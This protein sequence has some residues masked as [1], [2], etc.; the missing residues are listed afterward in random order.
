MFRSALCAAVFVGLAGLDV[1]AFRI[2]T[3]AS[4]L[5]DRDVELEAREG[6]ARAVSEGGAR[7]VKAAWWLDRL[8]ESL[9]HANT[10]DLE[11]L[12]M[13]AQRTADLDVDLYGDTSAEAARSLARLG[14]VLNDCGAAADAESVLRRALASY[15]ALGGSPDPDHAAAHYSLGIVLKSRERWVAAREH[16]QASL[17]MLEALGLGDA[18]ETVDIVGSLAV[19][20]RETGQLGD[21]RA[22]FERQLAIRRRILGEQHGL[23]ADAWN[24][25]GT[26]LVDLGLSADAKS[27]YQRAIAIYELNGGPPNSGQANALFNY[28]I[29]LSADLANARAVEFVEKGTELHKVISG[30]ESAD[31]AGCLTVLG[32]VYAERGRPEAA[33]TIFGQAATLWE[34]LRGPEHSEVAIALGNRA[35][36]L[37]Q[38]HRLHESYSD[39]D[40]AVTIAEHTLGSEHPWTL[41]MIQGRAAT[42]YDLGDDRTAADDGIRME[43]SRAS[44]IRTLALDLASEESMG[45]AANLPSGADIVL[46]ALARGGTGRQREAALDAT[47]RTR[48]SVLDAL[49]KR[50]RVLVSINDPKTN[51]Q[52]EHLAADRARLA[53][54]F[55]R[56]SSELDGSGNEFRQL[57][58]AV[59]RD[60]IELARNN[61]TVALDRVR[62]TAGLDELRAAMPSDAALV[63]F[64]RFGKLGEPT[65]DPAPTVQ[66]EGVAE[67]FR[68][69][70]GAFVLKPGQSEPDF[71]VV[72]KTAD[73]D[74]AISEWRARVA[75]A[76]PATTAAARV[77]EAR[78]RLTAARLRASLWDPVARDLGRVNRVFIVPDGEINVVSFATLSTPSGA[79][80][81]ETGPAIHYLSSERDLLRPRSSSATPSLLAFGGPDFEQASDSA[82]EGPAPSV[83]QGSFRG[84]PPGCLEFRR[85]R[86]KALPNA[87]LE[88]EEVGNL[89]MKRHGVASVRELTGARASEAAFKALAPKFDVLHLAT[90]GFVLA[91]DCAPAA[92][93]LSPDSL[94]LAGVVLAG[95]NR[96]NTA[97]TTGEDGVL[98]A[99]EIASLDLSGVSWAVLSACE[100]GLGRI[101]AGEGVFG[102]RRAFQVAGVGTL[103]MSLWKV[104][105]DRARQWMRSLY[106]SRTAG[107]DTV[108]AAR[109]ASLSILNSRRRSGADT[110]PFWW[111]AFVAAG[112]WE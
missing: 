36:C 62:E 74:A 9:V 107:H 28:G 33:L 69:Y 55:S 110:H 106:A 76:P 27:A 37:R 90:H 21:A 60:E 5:Q 95:A 112:D 14:R 45:L 75:S 108:T 54:E 59:N 99:E 41:Q 68:T 40:R 42:A 11:E 31:Y 18:V 35:T 19:L 70:Y 71:V 53:I 77:V 17:D 29:L 26:V 2:T 49:A 4:A 84:A 86:W 100:T 96:R 89:W 44:V 65:S 111:G 12:L 94:L 56:F 72:G 52:R 46:S 32:G 50:N 83:G 104:R 61:R 20:D 81:L 8:V 102:L 78:Y 38:L 109:D 73:I 15:D 103:V 80:L 39:F 13:L 16:L 66:G 93:S 51:E 3:A 1:P 23:V 30:P 57:Q 63:S 67:T 10:P 101:H 88:A 87:T 6:L 47:I 85:T 25:L 48:A 58:E 97:N 34:R 98:T 64:V 92:A 79:Y 22:G 43:R 91:G 7:S 24:N 82:R 105:D